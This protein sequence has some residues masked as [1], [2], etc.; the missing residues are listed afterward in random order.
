MFI[1]TLLL[2]LI[3]LLPLVINISVDKFLRLSLV[4]GFISRAEVLVNDKEL[5]IG[6]IVMKV[7]ANIYTRA[8]WIFKEDFRRS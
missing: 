2:V 4:R 3:Q 6:I 8:V 7:A 1:K 5:G